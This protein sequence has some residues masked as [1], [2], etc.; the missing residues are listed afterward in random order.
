MDAA[1]YVNINSKETSLS[2]VEIFALR[3]DGGREW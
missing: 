1:F 3:H 2:S